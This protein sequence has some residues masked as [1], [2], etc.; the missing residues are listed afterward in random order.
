MPFKAEAGLYNLFHSDKSYSKEA[1]LLKK[2]YP[3]AKTILEIGAGTGL[4]T[5]QLVKLGF[6]VTVIEPSLSMLQTWSIPGVERLKSKLEDIPEKR[7]KAKNFDLVVAHY[8]VLNYINHEDLQTQKFKLE[9]WGKD[10][11]I[12]MWSGNSVK[13]FT[14]KKA[15]GWHRVR[16]G[17]EWKWK[18]H[19]WYIYWGKG[20]VV[21]KHTLYL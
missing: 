5:K 10:V 11:S 21:E 16:I 20:F 15:K 6:R 4:L 17:F 14:H 8:D 2:K 18:A 12:E 13:F 19:L 3:E 1:L 9:R 7:F